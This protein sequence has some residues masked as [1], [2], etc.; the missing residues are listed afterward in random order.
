MIKDSRSDRL[1]FENNISDQVGAESV[2]LLHIDHYRFPVYSSSLFR[3][4]W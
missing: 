3:T 1:Y 4:Y 2:L